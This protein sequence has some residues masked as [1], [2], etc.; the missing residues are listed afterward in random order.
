MGVLEPIDYTIVDKTNLIEG[1]AEEFMVSTN[2]LGT[3]LGYSTKKYTEETAPKNWADVWD[4]EKFPGVRSLYGGD[5][6]GILEMALLAD[7]VELD[8][9]YDVITTDAGVDRAFAKMD[10][11][12]PH[13]KVWWEQ[14]TQPAQMLMDGEV[15][16]S[17]GWNG[18][19][20]AVID[21][22][23]PIA[24]VW[25][26]AMISGDGWVVPKGVKDKELVMQFINFTLQPKQQ[27]EMTKYITYGPTNSKSFEGID[28]TKA[29]RLPTSPDKVKNEFVMNANWVRETYDT[30][31]ERWK[32]WLIS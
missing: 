5:H 13:V 19:F 31:L 2:M 18:R 24:L 27:S 14:G 9:I 23:A 17:T 28:P 4:V 10:E 22:G 26:Q 8:K 1:T 29:E 7:G 20:D 21:Q 16:M 15:D 3:L 11:I 30:L 6:T 32:S 12:K 25:N